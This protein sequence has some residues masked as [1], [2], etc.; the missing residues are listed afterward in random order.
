MLRYGLFLCCIFMAKAAFSQTLGGNAAYSFLKLPAAP[1]ISAAGGV[2]VS[3]KTNE[4]SLSA[5]NPSLLSH[6]L[7]SQLNA[8]FNSFFGAGRLYSLTG[9]YHVEKVNT[10]FGGHVYY[11]DYGSLAATDAAGNSNG[12]F[13]PMDFV[14]QFSA[15][16]KYLEKWKY[17][18]TIKFINSSYQQYQSSA[19]AVDFGV[20]FFDSAKSFSASFV[21]KNMGLQL[22]SFA[23]EKE[24]LP[25]DLQVGITK[26]L[27]KSPFGFS[28][29]AQQ[30]HR[31][32]L[33]Y[34]DTVFNNENQ[35]TKPSAFNK[36]FN[37]FVFATH[38]HLGQNLEA[39]FGYN[40]LRR[41]EL[42]VPDASNGLTGFSAG[43]RIRFSRL[44]IQYARSTY[45]RGIGYHHIGITAHL[46]KLAGIGN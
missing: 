39:T 21:A 27:S 32:N 4:V 44:Q 7:H 3:Y 8:S 12:E 22:K 36:L 41:Q 14:V 33:L 13:R 35:F 38:I 1:I 24:D 43:L 19:L 2:N 34:N 45:Q 30:L 26:R 15:T 25:F 5:N 37:H 31:F 23:G 42:S 46:N 9:A 17:G 29:T 40:H 16:K 6:D 10:T 18:G 28:I 11:V 20:L